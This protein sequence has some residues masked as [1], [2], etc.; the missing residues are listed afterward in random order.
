MFVRN[1]ANDFETHRIVCGKF[2][3]L[4]TSAGEIVRAVEPVV[5]QAWISCIKEKGS[6]ARIMDKFNGVAANAKKLNHIAD[7][8]KN[9]MGG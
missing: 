4:T 1:E 5:Q 8:V 3:E 7:G 6:R 9:I 2:L